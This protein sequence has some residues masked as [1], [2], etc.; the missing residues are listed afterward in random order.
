M[1]RSDYYTQ[2]WN[3][4][5][6]RDSGGQVFNVTHERFGAL[7]D[8]STDD[9][10]A[11]QAAI[12]A[13]SAVGGT[14]SI[15]PG[16]YMVE[17]LVPKSNV[18]IQGAG[19]SLGGSLGSTLKLNASASTDLFNTST[20]FRDFGLYDIGL[21]GNKGNQTAGAD[22]ACW[23]VLR[24][25]A[26][27]Y[28]STFVKM[29]NV[30]FVSA[31]VGMYQEVPGNYHVHG[32][33]FDTCD[34]GAWWQHEHINMVDTYFWDCGIGCLVDEVLHQQWLSCYF[35]HGTSGIL[36]IG[37][38]AG[39]T[40][41]N[42][43]D[44]EQSSIIGCHFIDLTDGVFLNSPGDMRIIGNRLQSISNPGIVATSHLTGL[45]IAANDFIN[46][47]QSGAAGLKLSTGSAT[48]GHNVI[49]GNVIRDTNGT[50]LMTYG[51]DTSG[52]RDSEE[53][54][55]I[56]G[57]AIRNPATDYI[58]AQPKHMLS[59][60]LT[61]SGVDATPALDSPSCTGGRTSS[62]TIPNATWTAITLGQDFDSEESVS[63]LGM[64]ESGEPTR[65]T[66]PEDGYYAADGG[67]FWRG[68]STGTRR[69]AI[70]VNGSVKA[71]ATDSTVGSTFH[72]VNVSKVLELSADDYVELYV[73]QDSGGDLDTQATTGLGTDTYLSVT[74]LE[75]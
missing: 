12:D 11:I 68:N 2:A 48:S 8:G 71:R 46:C 74:K 42:T 28:G 19:T 64:W 7:G 67:V 47:G 16:T 14:V 1:A 49:S 31:Q 59:G 13:A 29:W 34:I 17:G 65:I 55:T 27:G 56:I 26:S 63:S 4:P 22:R 52:M 50:P 33:R 70:Y 3:A 36:G 38:Q 40:S 61:Q 18:V 66:V 53:V 23:R 25:A 15:P 75:R 45:V 41:N 30:L 39:S 57:N 73:Y 44:L 9:T 24:G 62:Q 35:A 5:L 51:V 10:A 69:V 32:C 54:V 60:N 20:F 21:H 43:S 58:N 72:S 6:I 37:A